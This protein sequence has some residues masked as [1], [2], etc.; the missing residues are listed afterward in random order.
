MALFNILKISSINIDKAYQKW[1]AFYVI[2][3]RGGSN[4]D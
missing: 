3:K 2:I 1:Y 4:N